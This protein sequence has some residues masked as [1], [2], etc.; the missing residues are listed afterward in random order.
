[1]MLDLVKKNRTLYY[2]VSLPKRLISNIHPT[3][4]KKV[5]Q[6]KKPFPKLRKFFLNKIYSPAST[7]LSPLADESQLRRWRWRG[8]KLAGENPNG[9]GGRVLILANEKEDKN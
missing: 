3:A 7:H 4:L 1:M 6:I 8:W 2:V 5:Y 9:R